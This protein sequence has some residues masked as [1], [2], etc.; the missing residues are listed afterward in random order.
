MLMEGG[1]KAPTGD[2][3]LLTLNGW[4]LATAANGALHGSS[5]S[6]GDDGGGDDDENDGNGDGEVRSRP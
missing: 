2:H 1:E 5:G 3:E 4:G 6:G